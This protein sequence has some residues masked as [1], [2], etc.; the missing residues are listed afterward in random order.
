METTATAGG[1]ATRPRDDA[2][3]SRPDVVRLI[4]VAILTS[5][6]A[7]LAYGLIDWTGTFGV[8]R[9]VVTGAPP[10]L[11]RAVE[12]SLAPLAD[13][14]LASLSVQTVRSLSR[15]VPEVLAVK[16]DRDFPSTLKVRVVLHRPVAVVRSGSQA[17]VV[18]RS[19]HVIE[20]IK[21]SASPELPRVWIPAGARYAAGEVL[22]SSIALAAARALARLP[23]PFP[24]RVISARGSVDDLSLIVG[25][26]ERV[27]LRLGGLDGL[28]LKLAVA[29]QVLRSL[30]PAEA[31]A[32]NYLDVSVPERPVAS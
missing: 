28:N 7:L 29:A 6:L 22:R 8:K 9:I 25:T 15:D 23:Q 16:V 19:G 31:G 5:A 26:T 4:A 1:E 24:L 20:T 17:W 14:S 3:A 12:R 18:S 11:V 13:E 32:L 27:E 2:L 10:D 21:P 30:S